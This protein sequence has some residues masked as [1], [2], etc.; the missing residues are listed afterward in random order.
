MS[1]GEGLRER[2][3]EVRTRSALLAATGEAALVRH[4]VGHHLIAP[5]HRLDGPA[6]HGQGDPDQK[7]LVAKDAVGIGTGLKQGPRLKPY[8]ERSAGVWM[9][10]DDGACR[11]LE[12][13]REGDRL[14]LERRQMG[15]AKVEG[16]RGLPPLRRGQREARGRWMPCRI[17]EDKL[18]LAAKQQRV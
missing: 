5:A 17:G 8:R 16:A 7:R 1:L 2:L 14:A 18:P 13:G 12:A 4:E 15:G 6:D 10:G 3:V 9:E 11:R